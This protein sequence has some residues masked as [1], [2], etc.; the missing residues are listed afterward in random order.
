MQQLDDVAGGTRIIICPV[1]NTKGIPTDPTT[2]EVKRFGKLGAG[3]FSM[4]HNL[5]DVFLLNSDDGKPDKVTVFYADKMLIQRDGISIS[6][7]N[8]DGIMSTVDISLYSSNH[9]SV[10]T[11]FP[12]ATIM[13]NTSGEIE[14]DG[15]AAERVNLVDLFF[16][17]V[18]L[19]KRDVSD[20]ISGFAVLEKPPAKNPGSRFQVCSTYNPFVEGKNR[21]FFMRIYDEKGDVKEINMEHF[22]SSK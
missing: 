16:H 20:P 21:N 4:N 14:I 15:P 13:K 3:T 12:Y 19:R 18:E 7:I 22:F 8:E 2:K 1:K 5:G 6:C 17:T 11:S 10:L 9:D